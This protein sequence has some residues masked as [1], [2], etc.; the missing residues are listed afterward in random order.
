[1]EITQSM[2]PEIAD[3]TFIWPAIMQVLMVQFI[4]KS[5]AI[6]TAELT[7]ELQVSYPYMLM[8]F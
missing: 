3:V 2:G 8:F 4:R 1:M 6:A 7:F 5:F